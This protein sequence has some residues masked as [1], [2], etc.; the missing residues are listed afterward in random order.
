MDCYRERVRVRGVEEDGV[1][2]VRPD[3]FGAWRYPRRSDNAESQLR[4]VLEKA[5]GL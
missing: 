4:S 5:L 1:V 3:Q 2:L